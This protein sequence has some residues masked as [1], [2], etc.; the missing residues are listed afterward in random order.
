M[1]NSTEKTYKEKQEERR[2]RQLA[3]TKHIERMAFRRA[4]MEIVEDRRATPEQRL[5]ALDRIGAIDREAA[6][7]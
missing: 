3:K 1:N 7:L 4:L 5:D 2:Q 6:T